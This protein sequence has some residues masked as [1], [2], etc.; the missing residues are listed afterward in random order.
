MYGN[1]IDG[2]FTLDFGEGRQSPPTRFRKAIGR[3]SCV[4]GMTSTRWRRAQC[5]ETRSAL[6]FTADSLMGAEIPPGCSRQTIGR[7]CWGWR[8]RP[9]LWCCASSGRAGRMV[10]DTAAA[11]LAWSMRF[12]P[13]HAV[14]RRVPLRRP[15][16][17]GAQHPS[18]AVSIG[19]GC[20]ASQRLV[21]CS[22]SAVVRKGARA[23][24]MELPKHYNY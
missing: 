7:T 22:S 14:T 21:A 2:G 9:P 11:A 13:E 8:R 12:E 16:P 1:S 10:K 24:P 5:A 6:F 18:A 23:E 17:R 19:A 20:A 3:A 15:V 4:A